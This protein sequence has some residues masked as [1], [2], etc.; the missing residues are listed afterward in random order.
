MTRKIA[1]GLYFVVAADGAVYQVTNRE[2]KPHGQRWTVRR[3][4]EN[5]S[6]GPVVSRHFTLA[7]AEGSL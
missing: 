2:K 5:G 6:V 3:V 4:R 1:P 7:D